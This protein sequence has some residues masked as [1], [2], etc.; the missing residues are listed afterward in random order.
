MVAKDSILLTRRVTLGDIIDICDALEAA[1]VVKPAP[2]TAPE[3]IRP[4]FDKTAYQRDYMR[5]RRASR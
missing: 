3:V 2:V 4:R 5:K 1:L